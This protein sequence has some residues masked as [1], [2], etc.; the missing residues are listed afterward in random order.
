MKWANDLIA[1]SRA[2]RDSGELPRLA[3]EGFELVRVS[4]LLL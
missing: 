3:E 1:A 2:F 4:E